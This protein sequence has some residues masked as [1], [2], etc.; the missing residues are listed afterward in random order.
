MFLVLSDISLD[1]RYPHDSLDYLFKDE[2][3]EKDDLPYMGRPSEDL[4]LFRFH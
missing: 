4:A 3:E 1:K 2:T